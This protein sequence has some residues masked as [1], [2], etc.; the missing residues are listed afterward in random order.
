MRRSRSGLLFLSQRGSRTLLH[1]VRVS[2][3]G[4]HMPGP[5]SMRTGEFMVAMLKCLGECDIRSSVINPR[6]GDGIRAMGSGADSS[7]V[8]NIVI[9][10]SDTGLQAGM[11]LCTTY[12][13]V[14][15]ASMYHVHVHVHVLYCP[16]VCVLFAHLPDCRWAAAWWCWTL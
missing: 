12:T 6:L 11:Y 4:S 8:E 15:S 16:C 1:G 9:Y 13:C 2:H 3:G 14:L 10:H 7:H 5:V